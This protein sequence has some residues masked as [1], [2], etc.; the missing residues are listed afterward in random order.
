MGLAIEDT[1]LYDYYQSK[2]K[3]IGYCIKNN[4]PL[5]RYI[6]GEKYSSYRLDTATVKFGRITRK[7]KAKLLKL[8]KSLIADVEQD[9]YDSFV[10]YNIGTKVGACTRIS[11]VLNE[12]LESLHRSVIEILSDENNFKYK[13]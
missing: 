2:N 13:K 8:F 5:A 1:P 6:K 3:K 4:I 9:G 11:H 7:G 12:D 10:M